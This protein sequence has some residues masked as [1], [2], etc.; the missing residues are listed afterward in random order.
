MVTNIARLQMKNN[1]TV[2]YQFSKRCKKRL[3]LTHSTLGQG[4]YSQ[5]RYTF[6]TEINRYGHHD[7]PI[8][9][10]VT[11]KINNN[12]TIP[13]PKLNSHLLFIKFSK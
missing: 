12:V 3:N 1:V 6:G 5:Y 13:D 11:A 4:R 8:Q 10:M 2:I 7:V 9:M